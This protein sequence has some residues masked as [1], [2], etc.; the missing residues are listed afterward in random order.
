[1]CQQISKQIKRRVFWLSH[2]RPMAMATKFINNYISNIV[3]WRGK[4]MELEQIEWAKKKRK[5]Q[6]K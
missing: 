6:R 2:C 3:Y 5:I 1:M 4:K